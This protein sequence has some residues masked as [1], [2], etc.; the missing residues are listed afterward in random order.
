[1]KIT[2]AE[3]ARSEARK[4]GLQAELPTTREDDEDED[5]S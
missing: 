4:R 2:V 1:M 3:L 5:C